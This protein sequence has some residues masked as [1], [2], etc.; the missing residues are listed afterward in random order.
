[1]RQRPDQFASVLPRVLCAGAVLFAILPVSAGLSDEFRVERVRVLERGI[2]HASSG[3]LPIA[4][5]SLGAVANVRNASLVRSTTTIPARQ[6]L[7]FGLRY[8]VEGAPAGAR[9]ELRLVTVFPEPGLLDPASGVRH[10][11]SEY[12]IRGSIG[13]QAYREFMFDHTWEI[14]AGEWIFEFWHDGRK[15]GSETFCVLDAESAPHR[16]DP[17]KANCGFLIGRG[18][19]GREAA[20][21]GPGKARKTSRAVV[22][23]RRVRYRPCGTTAGSI[24]CGAQSRGWTGSAAVF[25]NYCI[26][27]H[28]VEGGCPR[29]SDDLIADWPV[30][31]RVLA[32]AMR[33]SRFR[34]PRYARQ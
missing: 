17:P 26:A 12:T 3:N 13:T 20:A 7:R 34:M 18:D 32:G 29:P 30:S 4:H 23:R 28:F 2:F 5:S 27:V 1:M 10:Y 21:G 19:S 16:S 14:V 9:V 8:V 15:V 22:S 6:S 11:E 25:V 33:E 31:G 24:R